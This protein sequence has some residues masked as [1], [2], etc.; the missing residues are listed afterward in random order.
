M[1]SIIH[2]ITIKCTIPVHNRFILCVMLLGWSCT[3]LDSDN[4]IDLVVNVGPPYAAYNWE[5]EQ[6]ELLLDGSSDES[7]V[8]EGNADDVPDTEKD[9]Y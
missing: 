4:S 1:S 6:K 9:S 5:D 7:S 3:K 2:K 8:Q